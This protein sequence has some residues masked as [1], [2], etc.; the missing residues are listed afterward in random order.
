MRRDR[1]WTADN[2]RL[3]ASLGATAV[4]GFILLIPPL[5]SAFNEGGQVFGVPVIWVYLFVVWAVIIG[6]VALLVRRSG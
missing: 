5:L 1:K 4:L 2:T 3:T 6:L